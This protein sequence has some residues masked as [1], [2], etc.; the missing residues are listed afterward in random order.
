MQGKLMDLTIEKI[1][2]AQT[3]AGYF[4]EGLILADFDKIQEIRLT[5]FIYAVLN[6][7]DS[8]VIEILDLLLQ[9]VKG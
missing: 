5:D 8:K 4:D 9:S 6:A 2:K 7:E 1:E 3:E